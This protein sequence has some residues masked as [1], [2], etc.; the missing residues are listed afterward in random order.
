VRAP[1]LALVPREQTSREEHPQNFDG[2]IP[3]IP[4]RTTVGVYR[5]KIGL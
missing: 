4:K 5:L 1:K 2:A 3:A